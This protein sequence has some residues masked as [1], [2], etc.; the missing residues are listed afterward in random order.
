MLQLRQSRRR[1]KE[2]IQSVCTVVLAL[3][4]REHHR[5]WIIIGLIPL[6]FSL[7]RVIISFINEKIGMNNIDTPLR[8]YALKCFLFTLCNVKNHV[9]YKRPMSNIL[10]KE[11][12]RKQREGRDRWKTTFQTPPWWVEEPAIMRYIKQKQ[13]LERSNQHHFLLK[14]LVMCVLFNGDALFDLVFLLMSRRLS[15]SSLSDTFLF[16]AF[17]GLAAEDRVDDSG[18]DALPKKLEMVPLSESTGTI[19]SDDSFDTEPTLSVT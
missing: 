1:G 8:M 11:L 7:H 12:F 13:R 9:D 15:W 4:S 16:V 6:L 17:E 18:D 10:H 19:K 2:G 14:K 5:M 3:L